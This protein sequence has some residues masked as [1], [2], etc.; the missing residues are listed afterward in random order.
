M[1][2][3]RVVLAMAAEKTLHVFNDRSLD[4]LAASC[5]ILS[6]APIEDFSTPEARALLAEAD[7]LVTG[8]GAPYVGADVLR[9]A[10]R[11]KLIAHAAGT[12]K[13]TI[14]PAAYAAGIAVTHAADAN[15]VPVAEFTLAAII[16]ANKRVFELRDL[17]RA[18]HTRRSTWALMDEPIGNYRRTVGLIGASRIGRK[19]AKLLQILEVDVLLADPYVAKSDPV[20]R[21]ARLVDLET[22]LTES[23]IVSLHAPALPS[24][25]HMIGERQLRLMRDGA[26]FINT[27]RGML[28]DEAALVAELETG[29]INAI[30]DVTDPEIPADGSPLYSLPNVFLTPHVAGAGGTERLR[31]GEMT[32]AEIERFV[33][34]EPLQHAIEPDLLE[35]LA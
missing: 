33:S 11:L 18:D 29:R 16:F 4:R 7:I 31:L 3:P 12:V 20:T 27:A 17:Y 24:T 9:Q 6:R 8:W 1:M 23:D 13:Y 35:R 26:T 15:A 30:I 2:R 28:V 19:V 5:D 34:G 14:D 22:L 25:R 10:P 21:H 32:I